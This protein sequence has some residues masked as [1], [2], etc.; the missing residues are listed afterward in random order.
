MTRPGPLLSSQ[1]LLD[2]KEISGDHIEFILDNYPAETPVD[3]VLEERDPG[4]LPFF[5]REG[6]MVLSPSLQ[7]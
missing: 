6:E 5:E 7:E 1:V 3:L 4:T 2:R